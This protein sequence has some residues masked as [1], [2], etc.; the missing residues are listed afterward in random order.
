M[1]KTLLIWDVDDVLNGLTR[2][3]LAAS[4][5]QGSV[6]YEELAENPPHRILKC[7]KEEYLRS[8]D[9]FRAYHLA[10][11][12]P[13]RD[14]ME[15]FRTRGASFRHAALS[16]VPRRFA[17]VAARW[18]MEHYGDW[19]RSYSFVP[20]PRP[21]DAFPDYGGSKAEMLAGLDPAGCLLIDDSESNLAAARE[22]GFDTVLWP[23]P[24]NRAARRSPQE[25]LEEII[26]Q[27]GG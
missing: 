16:A 4:R 15:F 20:S 14:V 12:A 6:R 25:V 22:R 7:S 21:G 1:A 8:L 26:E 24:W 27:Y 3:W 23:R 11:L 18:V 19:I 5:W 17:G 10:E 9:E 13:E 2:S